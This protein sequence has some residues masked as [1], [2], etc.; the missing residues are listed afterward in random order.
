M[1]T[2]S[3]ARMQARLKAGFQECQSASRLGFKKERRKQRRL[4][5]RQESKTTRMK[6]C[7]QSFLKDRFHGEKRPKH[8]LGKM[9]DRKMQVGCSHQHE[10]SHS[11]K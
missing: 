6:E 2:G 3:P 8:R 7:V 10:V 9:S 4:S 5:G 11:A 1:M